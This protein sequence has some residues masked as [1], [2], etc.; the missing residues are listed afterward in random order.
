MADLDLD[1]NLDLEL[2]QEK[3]WLDELERWSET[4]LNDALYYV[5]KFNWKIIPLNHPLPNN[6]CSCGNPNCT[7]Q[8][9]HPLIGGWADVD[10]TSEPDKV[11]GWF[12]RWPYCNIGLLTG[13]KSGVFA[14]DVDGQD[15]R[16]SMLSFPEVLPVTPQTTSGRLDGGNHYYFDF[17]V[18]LDLKNSVRFMDGL[19]TRS[20]GGFVVL[21]SSLHHSGN[22]YSWV[23]SPIDIKLKPIPEWLIKLIEAGRKDDFEPISERKFKAE[24]NPDK[25]NAYTKKAIFDEMSK[26]Y[27]AGEGKRNKALNNAAFYLYQFVASGNIDAGELYR[28]LYDAGTSIGLSK[29]EATDTIRSGRRGGMK[30]PRQVPIQPESVFQNLKFESEKKE[31]DLF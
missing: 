28:I 16:Q 26:V 5:E 4:M 15:G 17:P 10:F 25:I 8:G 2:D 19:D 11:R 31:S 24:V 27:S 18:G 23:E 20:T 21:P 29:K 6:S 14:L 7:R 22:R 12:K 9:K 1:L 13:S 30:K 3:I